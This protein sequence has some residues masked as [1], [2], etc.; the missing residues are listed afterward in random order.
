MLSTHVAETLTVGLAQIA[1]VWLDREQT[2]AKVLFQ[3]ERA[4]EQGCQL[5]AFGEALAARIPVLD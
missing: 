1:P 2:L 5:V 3:I 4:A